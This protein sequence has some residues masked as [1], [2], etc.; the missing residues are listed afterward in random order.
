M[1]VQK[2]KFLSKLLFWSCFLFFIPSHSYADASNST[3]IGVSVVIQ[4]DNSCSFQF[5]A[6]S[7]LASRDYSR[8]D[9]M[10]C[11]NSRQ[12]P[13]EVIA[14]V[15]SKRV[16]DSGSSYTRIVSVVQ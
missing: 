1:S 10:T 11:D 9:S 6:Q 14:N 13:K 3:R 7:E 15:E 5:S 2:Y 8:L 16:L 4:N 12:N